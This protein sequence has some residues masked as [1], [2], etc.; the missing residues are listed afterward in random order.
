MKI[1]ALRSMAC[2]LAAALVATSTVAPAFAADAFNTPEF[3]ARFLDLGVDPGGGTPSEFKTFMVAHMEK[4]RKAVVA[5]G[6]RP[7]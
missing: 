2:Y 3:Q 1:N 6:A 5:S 7:E 4:M